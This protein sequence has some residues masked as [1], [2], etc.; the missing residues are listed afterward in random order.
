MVCA[1]TECVDRRIPSIDLSSI[2]TA[3]LLAVG[4]EH[5]T[6][7]A[8]ALEAA[9][10]E[11]F[12]ARL[13]AGGDVGVAAG[14]ETIDESF[15]VRLGGFGYLAQRAEPLGIV[16]EEDDGQAVDGAEL[17]DDELRGD[18]HLVELLLPHATAHVQ[19]R[20]EVDSG[21]VVGG[22]RARELQQNLELVLF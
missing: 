16:G 10:V 2:A 15:D 20:H 19:D 5:D 6:D 3:V 8:A 17:L 12:Q 7:D 21:T 4:H 13:K 9:V 18:L 11:D 1:E 22:A 14:D